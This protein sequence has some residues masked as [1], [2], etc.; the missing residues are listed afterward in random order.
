[1]PARLR[2]GNLVARCD[3]RAIYS[4]GDYSRERPLKRTYQPKRI[5]RQRKLGFIARMSTAGGRRV[6]RRRMLK[7]RQKLTV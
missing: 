3:V 6:I 2:Q 5:P 7:G 1:M 4:T